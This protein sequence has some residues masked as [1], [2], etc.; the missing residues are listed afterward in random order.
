MKNGM[1]LALAALLLTGLAC[2]LSVGGP[3]PPASPIP[4]STESV[5]ELQDNL[6]KAATNVPASGEVSL[7]VTEQQLTSIVALRLQEQQSLPLRDPQVFLRD[8]KIQLFGVAEAGGLR[9]NALI[10]ISAGLTPEGGVVFKAEEANFGPIPVPED[11][12]E[13]VSTTVNE[14]F[15]SNFSSK[16]RGLRI[17]AISIQD[18]R[19]SLTGRLIR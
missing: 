10:V 8:G 1:V 7:T 6:L 4:V 19:L 18:G 14:A 12:L 17:T 11:L 13:Q 15:K 9:A 16:A 2:G 3:T 5:G